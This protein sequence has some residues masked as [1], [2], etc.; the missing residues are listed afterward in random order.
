MDCT[1]KEICVSFYEALSQIKIHPKFLKFTAYEHE[2]NID[3]PNGEWFYTVSLSEITDYWTVEE[4]TCF[5]IKRV[6]KS[7][8]FWKLHTA[9]LFEQ[10]QQTGEKNEM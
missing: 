6:L 10:L 1:I 5:F 2:L 3:F 7:D 9:F 4:E 8:D